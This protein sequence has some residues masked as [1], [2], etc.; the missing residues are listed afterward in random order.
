M[1]STSSLQH[2]TLDSGEVL[3][4]KFELPDG[5]SVGDF[6]VDVDERQIKFSS[7]TFEEL[8][9]L[10]PA[11]EFDVQP[12]DAR[13]KY[14]KKQRT[15]R[16]DIPSRRRVPKV[17]VPG[18]GDPKPTGG[19]DAHSTMQELV[20]K[21]Q[22]L[23]GFEADLKSKQDA[24]NAMEKECAE[25]AVALDRF[26]R[27]QADRQTTLREQH[28]RAVASGAE[29]DRKVAELN[30]KAASPSA[31]IG[32][33][34][35]D[36][37]L[38]SKNAY[39][40]IS[41]LE[42]AKQHN[43]KHGRVARYDRKK[44][45]YAVKLETGELI[46]VKPSCLMEEVL[47]DDECDDA[48]AQQLQEAKV[49]AAAAAKAVGAAS[50]LLRKHDQVSS[51]VLSQKVAAVTKADSQVGKAAVA[52]SAAR[53]K[54]DAT[55]AEVQA[56]EKVASAAFEVVEDEAAIA[57]RL[58]AR[59]EWAAGEQAK[60]D[61]EK[62]AA[63]AEAAEAEAASVEAAA[64]AQAA[65]AAQAKAV[66]AA[67]DNAEAMAAAAVKVAAEATAVAAAKQVEAAAAAAAKAAMEERTA[68]EVRE[69]EVAQQVAAKAAAVDAA[70]A[71]VL[72]E[73]RAAKEADVAEAATAKEAAELAP[74][75]TE[76]AAA[77]GDPQGLDAMQREM[78]AAAEELK[79]RGN[80]EFKR[81]DFHHAAELFGR[82]SQLEPCVT[83]ATPPCDPRSASLL[84]L[85]THGR[86]PCPPSALMLS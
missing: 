44:D 37:Q 25:A 29:A 39:V 16:V 79:N 73:A 17:I 7:A 13:A 5:A 15:L 83:T 23:G 30:A 47:S 80:V 21:K 26:R 42:G 22:E 68:R 14:I 19:G 4:V 41:G 69:A 59:A 24:A 32:M 38:F 8:V 34:E 2:L 65:S 82:A 36:D 50:T 27:E 86:Y 28:L 6:D 57:A 58:K 75:V 12:N 9:I 35:D 62:E 40:M 63:E 10:L 60:A 52:A 77:D 20:A 84:C 54:V 76:S 66:K 51:G 11:D 55:L 43:D 67:K 1:Q 61:R 31:A 64:A 18:P 3:R 78:A 85:E 33:E 81:G 45:R 71:A 53:S 49:E 46:S 72:A 56:L 48:V 70:R 74:A